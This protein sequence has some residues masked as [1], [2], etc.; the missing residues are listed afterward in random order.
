MLPTPGSAAPNSEKAKSSFAAP[1]Q[2]RRISSGVDLGDLKRV[3]ESTRKAA[4]QPSNELEARHYFRDRPDT[5]GSYA[6]V[7]EQKLLE[8]LLADRE[9]KGEGAPQGS[10]RTARAFRGR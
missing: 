9:Q 2:E 8:E 1:A 6:R 10:P 3:D 7:K 5:L 4:A